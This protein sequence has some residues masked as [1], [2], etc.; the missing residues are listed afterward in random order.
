MIDLKDKTFKFTNE[1]EDQLASLKKENSMLSTELYKAS[2][3]DN[4]MTEFKSETSKL[5]EQLEDQLAT[6][7]K[8]NSMLKAE[9]YKALEK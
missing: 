6:L 4:E 2:E 3:K 5:I 9:L 1:L 8:E 7:R